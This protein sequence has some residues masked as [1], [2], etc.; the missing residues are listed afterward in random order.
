MARRLEWPLTFRPARIDQFCPVVQT[1]GAIGNEVLALHELFRSWGVESNIFSERAGRQ[2]GI[3]IRPWSNHS[4]RADDII[5]VH[6]SHWS[7]LFPKVFTSSAQK[8]LLYHNITPPDFF[9]AHSLRQELSSRLAIEA[10]P[11][12][13]NTIACS[14]AHSEFSAADLR[15]AGYDNVMV[16]PYLLRRSLYEQPANPALLA[17]LRANHAPTLLAVGRIAP[18]KS[19]E[20]TFLTLDYLV[21]HVDPRWRLV[22][23]G[24]WGGFELYYTQLC[25]LAE[26]M[27]LRTHTFTGRVR[28]PDLLAYYECADALLCV[29]A[30]EGFGVPLVEAMG[31]DVPV[32]AAAHGAMP[33]VL[34]GAGVTLPTADPAH[35][36]EAIALVTESSTLR[37]ALLAAQRSRAAEFSPAVVQDCWRLLLGAQAAHAGQMAPGASVSSGAE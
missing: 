31:R 6:Y 14:I 2:A 36:A 1:E 15:R 5:L 8:L 25:E 13:S 27:G 12:F 26:R 35:A 10:L 33:E 3:P 19:L 9:A 17:T 32:F 23:V 4:T 29:S 20:Q 21:R 11:A 22:M 18:H 7:E 37:P 24:D 28:Q 16:V 34:G 30:H